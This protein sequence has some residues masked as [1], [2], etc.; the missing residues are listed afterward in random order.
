MNDDKHH[1]KPNTQGRKLFDHPK[2]PLHPYHFCYYPTVISFLF[3]LSPSY[4][5][6]D[7]QYHQNT[8]LNWTL[9]M[10]YR[11]TDFV[12][13]QLKIITYITPSG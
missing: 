2:S 3:Q 8:R 12:T 13:A 7:D 5:M 9:K 4:F 10:G 11:A 6:S 1:Q